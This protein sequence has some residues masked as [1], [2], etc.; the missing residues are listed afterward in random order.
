MFAHYF[1]IYTV[2][3]DLSDLL[4]DLGLVFFLKNYQPRWTLI[5]RFLSPRQTN[6][7]CWVLLFFYFFFFSFFCFNNN[8]VLQNSRVSSMDENGKQLLKH[9]KF[10][11]AIDIAH[12]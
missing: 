6:V 3:I 11:I 1:S 7:L 5:Y 4:N 8:D 10:V 9:G 2:F 12:R